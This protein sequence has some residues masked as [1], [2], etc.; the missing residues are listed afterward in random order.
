M[1]IIKKTFTASSDGLMPSVFAQL[2]SKMSRPLSSRQELEDLI[3]RNSEL[4]ALT[5][6]YRKTLAVS[7]EFADS[8]VKPLSPA[9][10]FAAQLDGKGRLLENV[11]G[12]VG[13]LGLDYDHVPIDDMQSLF[14]RIK[15]AA[16]TLI[17]YRTISGRG[18]RIIV[19]YQRPEGCELSFVELHQAMLQKA[20]SLYDALLGIKADRQCVDFLRLS[21]LAHDEQAYFDWDAEPLALTDKEQARFA[22][23][24]LRKKSGKKSA[25][26]RTKTA[27]G[28][29]GKGAKLSAERP[30]MDEAEGHIIE[31]LHSWGLVF[32][33]HHHNEYVMHFASLCN[34]YGIEF[35][36]VL[37]YADTHFSNDYPDTAAVIKSCYK[38]TDRFGT[39]HYFREGETYRGLTTVKYIKQWIS[40]RYQI[41]RNMVTGRHE[42]TSRL[43]DKPKYLK[44]VNLDDNI[45]NSLWVEMEEEG[46]HVNIQKLISVIHSDFAQKCDPVE[47]YL[48]SLPPW[49]GKRDY[50]DELANR[51]HIIPQQGYHHDQA[52]FRKYFRKWIVAMVVGWVTPEVV[53][54]VMLILVGKGGI[55]KS[56][57]FNYLLPPQLRDYYL[58]ESAAV[59]TDKDFMEAFSCKVLMCLDEFDTTFGKNL[60]AFKSNMTKLH[61]SIR[62]PYDRFRSDLDHRASVVGTTNNQQIITDLENRRYSPWMV[63]SIVSPIDEPLD[64]VGIYAQCVALGKEVKERRQRGEDGWVYWLTQDDIAEMQQ[65]NSLFMVPNYAEEQIKRF[66][67]APMADTPERFI[68]FRYTAEIVERICTN[69]AM[70]RNFEHQSIGSI[71]ARLGFPKAHR[72]K[73]NGWF[74]V[75]KEC[76]EINSDSFYRSTDNMESASRQ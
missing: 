46:M 37:D 17:A 2:D 13:C 76:A 24:L 23:S 34:R 64:Y 74:V 55:Y 1:D 32:E 67:R 22:A 58:N 5:E 11:V 36:E 71:M 15:L 72:R 54:Q 52:T 57:F 44:W 3:L 19:S 33:P 70:R 40:M 60:N 51:I 10:C 35:K 21:G 4:A 56:T 39:W 68:K 16:N 62:R 18:L 65:H 61:F 43:V 31:T 75:E 27:K 69:P 48:L 41:Q 12:E 8:K 66:Y 28:S 29:A 20:M 26:G 25:A 14:D 63:E 59:Y 38:K 47:D 53:N 9:V 42:I 7:K 30:T 49:D 50:I 45:L 73:G 6:S